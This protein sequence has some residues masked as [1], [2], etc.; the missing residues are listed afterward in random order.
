MGIAATCC[1]DFVQLSEENDEQKHL[2]CLDDGSDEAPLFP[3][4]DKN[5]CGDDCHCIASGTNFTID[6]YSQSFNSIVSF[7]SDQNHLYVEMI[8]NIYNER[9]LHPPK[10]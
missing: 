2:C 5:C 8:G 10:I 4:G 9:L 7:I 3:S 6:D 1:L